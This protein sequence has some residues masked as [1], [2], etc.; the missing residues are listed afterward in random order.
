MKKKNIQKDFGLKEVRVDMGMFD[1]DVL[2]VVGNC[3][4]LN[5]YARWKFNDDMFAYDA[6][7]TYGCCLFR[8]GYVPV[9]WLPKKPRTGREFATLAHESLHAVH[10]M[11]DWAGITANGENEEVVCHAMTS[12]IHKILK[13]L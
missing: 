2:C 13:Q 7:K 6:S 10:R 1:F 9:I 8:R 11:L 3:K 5:A 4:K 12:L